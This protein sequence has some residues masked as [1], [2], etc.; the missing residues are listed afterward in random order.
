M[1]EFLNEDKPLYNSRIIDTFIR[2][3]KQRYSFVNVGE[4]LEYAGM[5]PYEVADQ[6]HWFTQE[7]IDRFYERLSAITGNDNIAREAGQYSASP[8]AIGVM[9]QYVLG[10]VGPARVY[11]FIRKT[12]VNFTR[13]SLYES[14]RLASN[15]ME[16]T[17][18][19]YEG[20][21]EK[22]FQCENRIG[23]FEA[24]ALVFNNRLNRID[25]PECMFKGGKVCRYI[26]SWE[27]SHSVIWS[28]VR[29]GVAVIFLALFMAQLSTEP[30]VAFR[31]ILPFAVMVFLLLSVIVEKKEKKQLQASVENIKDSTD[32][33]LEQININYNN[34]LITNEIGQAISRQTSVDD[35]L[36]SVIQVLEKRL[37]YDRG[38]IL[39]ASPDKSRLIFQAGF[40]YDAKLVSLLRKAEFH[41]DRPESRGVFVISFR[42]QKPFLINNIDDIETSLSFR[43]LLFAKKLGA[44][45]FI[46]CPI[47]C[48]GEAVGVLAV[49]NIKSKRPLVQSDLSLL[50]GVAPVIGITI[51][52]A[53]LIEAKVKQFSSLLQVM[54]ASIDA[55]DPMT[56]GHSEKV[57][58]YALGICGEMKLAK[59]YSEMIRVAALLHDYGKIGIPDAILKK[60]GRLTDIEYEL[61]K[62]HASK[63]RGILEQ[64][65]FEGIYQQVPSI[66]GCHHEKID[67]SGYPN[68]LRGKDIP[69]G[70]KIIAVADFFEAITAKR[71]YREPMAVEEAFKLLREESGTHFEKKLV[72]ALISYYTKN[73]LGKPTHRY[74]L[75]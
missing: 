60:D 22:Q 15:R 6:G 9:R 20:T 16:I 51:H 57:T 11:E 38:L 42:E 33:L 28:R 46:C 66:A 52:N 75:V 24:I 50:M 29:V 69:L 73:Y 71:H 17:V 30:V 35:I 32:R 26:V 45:S 61:V 44:Q 18:T 31:T 36:D 10:L 8:D 5:K 62:Y 53:N 63:T 59:D 4:L 19:P 13:S 68:G 58:E 34:A 7:Q 43:S 55:R 56:A 40:G 65:H 54:A 2:L 14:R 37:D 23:F 21:H 64:V 41:L 48:E 3:I 1:S 39:L 47:L 72:E 12:T 25:H 27:E 70:A 67:G 74:R 49:D